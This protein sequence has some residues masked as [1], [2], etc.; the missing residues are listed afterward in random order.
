MS[1]RFVLYAPREEI[2]NVFNVSMG[3]SIYFDADYNISPGSLQPMVMGGDEER[4][5]NKARWGLIH[6][7]AEEERAGNKNNVIPTEDVKG[8]EWFSECVNRRRCLIPA[9]GFYKWRSSEMKQMPFYIRLLSNQ[10]TAFAGIYDMWTSASGREVYS[11]AILTTKAN[12]LI[13]PVDKR[14]PVLL[15][16]EDFG[17]WLSSSDL[18]EELYEKLLLE[19]FEL[20]KLAVNRVSKK[21]NDLENNGRELIQPVP[22]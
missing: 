13:E 3:R 9:N 6:P 11:F 14:M 18:T 17:K 8:N 21:V 10:L 22:K 15:R 19:P 4:I 2:E 7:D 5:C 12:S 20:T 1:D 16:R